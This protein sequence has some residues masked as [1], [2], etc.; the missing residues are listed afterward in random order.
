M[1]KDTYNVAI[2]GATGAVGEQMREVLDERQF[3]IGEVRL[4]AS[5]RSVHSYVQAASCRRVTHADRL[6][7]IGHR[8]FSPAAVSAANSR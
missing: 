8:L 4:L 6:R 2:V 1:K 5:E 3:P 7:D